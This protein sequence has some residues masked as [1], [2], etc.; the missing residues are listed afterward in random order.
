MASVKFDKGSEEWLMFMD[1]WNLCQKYWQAERT[2]DYW[3]KVIADTNA[4]CEKYKVLSLA[5]KLA[6]AFIEDLDENYK[7]S[8]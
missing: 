4:F 8:K 1:Y 6:L 2:D 3:E 5:K 7:K